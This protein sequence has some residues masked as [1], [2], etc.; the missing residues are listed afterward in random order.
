MRVA[1]VVLTYNQIA[2]ERR[3]LFQQ[4]LDSLLATRDPHVALSLFVV[5]NS[6]DD[7]TDKIVAELGGYCST[8]GI[9]TCGHGT[10]LAARVGV[11]AGADLVVLSDDDM[12][13]RPGWL[14]QLRAWW[15][16][17]PADIIL[18]GCHL[19]PEF[20]WNEIS[21]A[22]TYG[23][24]RGL[25]RR[26]TGAAS[27]SFRPN[28]WKLIGPIPEQQQGVGDVPACHRLVERGLRIAQLDLADHA[29][30]GRSS[31]G[32]KTEAMYGWDLE[33]V[34]ARLAA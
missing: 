16:R 17:S 18:T 12:V 1:A 13:W 31:W 15:S 3:D 8:D 30:I 26:S 9:T 5:D 2:S 34:R 28:A 25:I 7:G 4:T 11:G 27:W 6:S 29:G 20:P 10:N 23:K 33:P 22:A 19:E 24:V 14:E 21:A 32:N